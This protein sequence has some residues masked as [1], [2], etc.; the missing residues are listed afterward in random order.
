MKNIKVYP[1]NLKK[2]KKKYK[3]VK[4]LGILHEV[5]SY[6]IFPIGVGLI[7]YN[8]MQFYHNLPFSIATA[9]TL[10]G[11]R[12][13]LH[14]QSSVLNKHSYLKRFQQELLNEESDRENH[15]KKRTKDML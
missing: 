9:V 13:G 2:S 4:S 11:Y 1:N 12:L 15:I 5:F 7:I 8:D 14:F 10:C 3:L 6:G